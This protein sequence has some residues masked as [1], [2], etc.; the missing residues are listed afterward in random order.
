M[1][2]EV[3][4][5]VEDAAVRADDFE[6]GEGDRR[7]RDR[8]PF[9]GSPSPEKLNANTSSSVVVLAV[10]F[11]RRISSTGDLGGSLDSNVDDESPV[12]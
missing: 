4:V 8:F 6:A 5:V 1:E 10:E 7:L 12:V 9:E 2:E 11:T 3:E